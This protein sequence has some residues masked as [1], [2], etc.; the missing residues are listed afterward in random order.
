MRRRRSR[1]ALLALAIAAAGALPANALATA[2]PVPLGTDGHGVRLVQRGHP[3]HLVVLLSPQRYRKVVGN[4]L[5][6]VCAPVPEVTLGGGLV[7][8]PRPDFG[9]LPRPR[10]GVV[11]RLR[12]PRRRTPLATT[13]SPDWD[14]CAMAVRKV[15][16][17]GRDVSTRGF[18]TVP[19]TPTGA[20]FSDERD[21]AVHVIVSE[22]LFE[23]SPR[24]R[25]VT[26]RRIARLMHAVVLASPAETPP[27]GRLGI[28]SDG[29]RHFYAAQADRAGDLLF[30][31]RDD[32]VTRTNL[33][34]YLQDFSLL[35]GANPLP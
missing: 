18:G 3:A 19:L 32:E 35:W 27:D 22:F 20:A 31:E 15:R 23:F 7:G 13:L 30:Y 1:A 26:V 17:H 24:V 6:V 28:Y 9:N 4:Q 11:A 21:A 25:R 14:W 34:R 16:H 33:L 8:G 5:L 10:G 12:P 29:R 2:P